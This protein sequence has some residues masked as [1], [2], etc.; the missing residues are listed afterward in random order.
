M[1]ADPLSLPL[2]FLCWI[3]ARPHY[4]PRT[5]DCPSPL[6]SSVIYRTD[7]SETLRSSSPSRNTSGNS[8]CGSFSHAINPCDFFPSFNAAA[9]PLPSIMT[10]SISVARTCVSVCNPK[11]MNFERFVMRFGPPRIMRFHRPSSFF[12]TAAGDEGHAMDG[13]DPFM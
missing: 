4:P 2:R 6:L 7:T 8:I 3:S 10:Q 5:A 11:V 12:T 13:I 1:C 9:L